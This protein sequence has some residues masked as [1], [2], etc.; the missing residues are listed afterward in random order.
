MSGGVNPTVRLSATAGGGTGTAGNNEQASQ[1]SDASVSKPQPIMSRAARRRAKKPPVIVTPQMREDARE[2]LRELRKYHRLLK[3]NGARRK[4][5]KLR[6]QKRQR[7][8]N[9]VD[10]VCARFDTDCRPRKKSRRE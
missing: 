2:R 6:A 8:V 4:L 10:E 1:P 7:D 5:A 9:P 3:S